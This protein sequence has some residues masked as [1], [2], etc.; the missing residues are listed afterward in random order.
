M[1]R[2]ARTCANIPRTAL[3]GTVIGR[4]LNCTP[5]VLVEFSR[6]VHVLSFQAN[7]KEEIRDQ[8]HPSSK[9][10]QRLLLR[11]SGRS[12]PKGALG[13]NTE[14]DSEAGKSGLVAGRG[15]GPGQVGI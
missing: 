14:E 11:D 2:S 12:G 1:K 3:R 5:F 7:Y 8:F 9:L 4:G 6:Y 10:T 15:E 13:G